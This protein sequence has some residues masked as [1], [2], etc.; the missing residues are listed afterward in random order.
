MSE[1][2]LPTDAS[3]AG[4]YLDLMKRC[5]TGWIYADPEGVPFDDGT[6]TE[7]RDW[8]AVGHTMVGF[9]RLD[10]VQGN[11]QLCTFLRNGLNLIHVN[12]LQ[13]LTIFWSDAENVRI[14]PRQYTWSG[15]KHPKLQNI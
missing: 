9:K 13:K 4:L 15:T 1:R 5:L 14:V 6:R 12:N 10:N 11:C 8:P 3:P 2:P 7:G